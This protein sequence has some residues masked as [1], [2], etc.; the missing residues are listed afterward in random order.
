MELACI[1]IFNIYIKMIQILTKDIIIHCMSS[2]TTSIMSIHNIYNFIIEHKSNDVQLYQEELV[3]TDLINNILIATAIIKDILRKHHFT[4]E[5][6]LHK[7]FKE[8]SLY[9]CEFEDDFNIVSFIDEHKIIA[10]IPQPVQISLRI[11]LEVIDRINE[12]LDKV[13]NKI[14][15][16]DKSFSKYFNRLYLKTELEQIQTNNK[17]FE[18]RLTQLIEIIKI[19]PD[20]I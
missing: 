4:K 6:D 5:D 8:C 15:K 14:I 13:K 17:L 11:T 7:I 19:Y 18:K 20:I 12:L 3:K 9:K 1:N 16:Y 10:N 2:L